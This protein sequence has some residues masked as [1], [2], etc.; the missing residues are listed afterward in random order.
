MKWSDSGGVD[1][2]PA[3]A[4]TH[5]AYCFQLI[6]LGTQYNEMYEIFKRQV[7]IGFELPGELK[8]WKDEQGEHTAPY[9]VGK[10]YTMSLSEKANLRRDMESWR[11]K[12][13]TEQELEGFDPK[14]ILGTPAMVSVI[15]KQ[16][17]GKTKANISSVS[18]LM[19]GMNMPAMFHEKVYFSLDEFSQ[20]TFDSIPKGFQNIIRRSKEWQ[21]NGSQVTVP[22]ESENSAPTE[23]IDDDKPF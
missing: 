3:P 22:E 10:F 6:D 18:K 9:T 20:A 12:P 16:S 7:F 23:F 17:Q 2:E 21:E 4:G 13:F 5:G 19:K 14:N 15:H 1:F 11:G 8:T